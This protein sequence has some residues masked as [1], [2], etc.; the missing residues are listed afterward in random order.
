MSTLADKYEHDEAAFAEERAV[1]HVALTLGSLLRAASVTQRELATR[2]G[3]TEGRVSQLL[4]G[5]ANPTVRTLSRI[6]HAL[7]FTMRI[8]FAANDNSKCGFDRGWT[9]DT[10]ADCT[11]NED[12]LAMDMAA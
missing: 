10:H 7:G 6:A 12:E 11:A 1:A 4:S 9:K 3:L 5:N 8:S 2:L